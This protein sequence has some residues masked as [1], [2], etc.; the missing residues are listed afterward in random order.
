MQTKAV[1][2]NFKN[3][4]ER[5]GV[6]VTEPRLHVLEIIARSKMPLTAY[7][8]LDLLGEKLEKPKP[9]TAYRALE[10]LTAQG[11]I[12]RIESL[13]AY[14]ACGEDHKHHGSQFMVCDSCGHVEEVHLCHVP[15]G[16]QTQTSER[17]FEISHWN[18][19]LHGRCRKCC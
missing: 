1:L 18:A 3:F 5:E 11:F 13:N 17:G 9:P 4:C 8:V 16:L 7:E 6:R 2:R 15:K 12:H 10:F 19:E 14:V